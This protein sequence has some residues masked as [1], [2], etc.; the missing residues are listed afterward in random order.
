MSRMDEW[1]VWVEWQARSDWTVDDGARRV[2]E[3][4]RAVHRSF[5]DGNGAFKAGVTSKQILSVDDPDLARRVA[6]KLR[7]SRNRSL[8]AGS[9]LLGDAHLSFSS[10][11]P[12][13]VYMHLSQ[14]ATGRGFSEARLEL[15]MW[16]VCS[17]V[18]AEQPE[19]VI[20]LMADLAAIW[21]ARNA[22]IDMTHVQI[23]RAHV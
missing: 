10:V 22:W 11:G 14:L 3:S 17:P 8:F 18:L 9:D 16:P 4:M 2:A 12:P 7:P 1:E 13:G 6:P 19:H 20:A 23:G 21:Q 5:P 15:K